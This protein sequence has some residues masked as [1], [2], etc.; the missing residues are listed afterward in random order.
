[1]RMRSTIANKAAMVS[2]KPRTEEDV[3]DQ[4]RGGPGQDIYVKG[5]LVMHTLRSLIGDEAFF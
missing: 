5:A 3:Y 1:M 4:K 2:G